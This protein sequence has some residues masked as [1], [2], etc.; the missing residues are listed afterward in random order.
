MT[1]FIVEKASVKNTGY[2]PSGLLYVEIVLRS[3]VITI[4]EPKFGV[5][6]IRSMHAR[7]VLEL[8]LDNLVQKNMLLLTYS[9]LAS[10]STG[11]VPSPLE[12]LEMA[13]SDVK[14]WVDTARKIAPQLF[15][16]MDEIE[17]ESETAKKEKL[18]KKEK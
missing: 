10:V 9:A 11:D 15:S 3:R 2:T 16:W 4:T 12:M 13:D 1:E 6:E 18:K 7:A 5:D 17:G 14:F 8:K